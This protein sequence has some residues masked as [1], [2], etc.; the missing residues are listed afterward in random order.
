VLSL[1]D[2]VLINGRSDNEGKREE[3]R[4]IHKVIIEQKSM[5][6]VERAV[7]PYETFL[8]VESD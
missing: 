6:L 4:D 3:T 1:L 8:P 5:A 2:F 7:L